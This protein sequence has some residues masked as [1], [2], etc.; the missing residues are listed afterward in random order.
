MGFTYQILAGVILCFVTMAITPQ[1]TTAKAETP[2][3]V[4]VIANRIDD[5][6]SLD[7]AERTKRWREK[8][9]EIFGTRFI[10]TTDHRQFFW[11]GI[12]LASK[13]RWQR[14]NE[15]QLPTITQMCLEGF[16]ADEWFNFRHR[17]LPRPVP[18]GL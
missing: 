3:E 5:I 8:L 11:Y 18:M 4:L 15:N 12:K 10:Q 7:P 13:M 14:R 2:G 6:T 16:L 17:V 1:S 9:R